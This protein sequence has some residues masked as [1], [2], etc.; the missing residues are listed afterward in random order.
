MTISDILK[1][2]RIPLPN[3]A[4]SGVLG[5]AA[6][7]VDRAAAFSISQTTAGV[8]VTLPPPTIAFDADFCVVQNIGTVSI[9]VDST[10][11]PAKKYMIFSY[12]FDQ[13][14]PIQGGAGA[15]SLPN[16]LVYKYYEQKFLSAGNNIITHNLNL[17][18]P[19]AYHLELRDDQTGAQVF[20]R[21]TNEQAN[22]LIINVVSNTATVNIT[23]I[24]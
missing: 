18:T 13:W 10:V 21:I 12:G 1:L 4:A 22:S 8:T 3:F 11:I 16:N 14:L 5:T 17:L 23:I 24:G 9:T 20:A 19:K 6:A 15:I 2:Q 7:T